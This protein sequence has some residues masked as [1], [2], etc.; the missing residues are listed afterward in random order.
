MN[1]RESFNQMVE[2]VQLVDDHVLL[3]KLRNGHWSRLDL[4]FCLGNVDGEFQWGGNNFSET[5]PS[6]QPNMVAST[7]NLSE[8]IGV[9]GGELTIDDEVLRNPRRPS[10]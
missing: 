10:M 2:D 4:D 3:A 1:N 9:V 8:D 6:G 7:V 5:A